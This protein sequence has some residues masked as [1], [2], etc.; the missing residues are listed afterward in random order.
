MSRR[1]YG[2]GSSQAQSIQSILERIPLLE[3]V[4][5]DVLDRVAGYSKIRFFERGQWILEKGDS[6]EHLLFLLTGQLQVV[7]LTADGKEIGLNFLKPGDYFGEL[8]VIDGLPR[9]ASVVATANSEVSFLPRLQ[10]MELIYSQPAVAERIMKRLAGSIRKASDYRSILAIPNAQQRVI[11]LLIQMTSTA[12][13][14]MK[15]VDK[16]PTRQEMA[17]MINTSRETVSRVMQMLLKRKIVEKD[18]RRLIVRDPEALQ[19]GG[20]HGKR[21]K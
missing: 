10:A 3:G 4:P 8:S 19:D 21:D 11:A 13:G 6:G 15:V 18:M 12:P 14:G 7:D 16:L 9:T 5:A 17:I 2:A 20:A 1:H